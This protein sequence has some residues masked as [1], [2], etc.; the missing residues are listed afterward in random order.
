MI[1]SGLSGFYCKWLISNFPCLQAQWSGFTAIGECDQISNIKR[2]IWC[3]H[4]VSNFECFRS[5]KW[6]NWGKYVR[7]DIRGFERIRVPCYHGL[8]TSDPC[9][10]KN[11]AC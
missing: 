9:F 5:S 2:H 7:H 4:T 6:R 3:F 11:K 1:F 10:S 8:R